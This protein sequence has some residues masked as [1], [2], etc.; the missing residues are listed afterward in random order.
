M[1]TNRSA[2]VTSSNSLMTS[3]AFTGGLNTE[4][5]G[6]VDSADFTKDELNMMI[7]QDN[8]RSRRPGVDY[9]EL[10]KFNTGII[11]NSSELLAFSCIE[12]YDINS[13]DEAETYKQIPYIVVQAGS[14]LLFYVN[15]GQPY[16]ANQATFTLN[17]KDYALDDDP[18]DE[19]YRDP[20]KYRCRYAIAY[21]CLFITSEA[22]R[23]IRLR[24]AQ[25]EKLPVLATEFP[26]CSVS[27]TAYQGQFERMGTYKKQANK[28][29]YF[30]ILFDNTEKLKIEVPVSNA[31]I[32][33]LP[34]SYTLAAAFNALSYLARRGI[35]AYPNANSAGSISGKVSKDSWSPADW[36]T[37]KG[38]STSVRGLKITIE[39][40]GWWR[41]EL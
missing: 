7:R 11:P 21:G 20:A 40:Y 37:F 33:P 39:V 41:L 4:L 14:K 3:G 34:N 30:R 32:N 26:Y 29:A 18:N 10:Y 13:P 31:T 27:C 23:P 35:T 28:K 1:A 12:W 2:G 9:E 22:I 6:I 17:L 8:C 5:S 36:I 25:K 15:K 38:D 24:A 16:S 19:N